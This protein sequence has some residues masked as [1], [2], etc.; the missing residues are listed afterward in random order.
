M[1]PKFFLMQANSPVKSDS[2][3]LGLAYI[4]AV[5]RDNGYDVKIVDGAAFHASYSDEQ[6]LGMIQDFNPSFVGFLLMSY[7]VPLSYSMISK[8]KKRFPGIKIIAGGPHVAVMPEEVLNHGV[9]IAFLGEAEHNILDI[10][11]YHE[12]SKKLD[13]I[14]GIAFK[15]NDKVVF[16]KPAKLVENL[17]DLPFP[18]R[19]LFRIGDY[20]RTKE[21]VDCFAGQILTSRGCPFRCT[22]CS[23]FIAGQRYR[24]RTPKNVVDE[25]LFVKRKYGVNHFNFIDD[26]FTIRIDRIREFC[27]LLKKEPELR[28]VTWACASR[29]DFVTKELLDEIKA[30]GCTRIT[31]GVESGDDST[32]QLIKKGPKFTVEKAREVVKATHDVGISCTV[33]FM[34]GFP[35]ETPDKIEKTISFMKE[36]SPYVYLIMRGGILVPYPG[37]EIYETYKVKYGFENWWLKPSRF[38]GSDR[39]YPQPLFRKIFF[40]DGGMLEKSGF[41]GYSKAIK[42]K[43]RKAEKFVSKQFIERKSSD[44]GDRFHAALIKFFMYTLLYSSKAAHSVH[45][46]VEH[47][48]V[49][50][51]YEFVRNNK[52]YWKIMRGK[53]FVP[54]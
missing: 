46:M 47:A 53:K 19:D 2:P 3:V 23:N 38:T 24:F 18:A 17:D 26:A 22:F 31:Y 35:W 52:I 8:V 1:K 28:G 50:K 10:A 41:F 21:E 13:S 44:S 30:A 34:Y 16:T 9:D 33:T 27:K 37:T 49:Y 6:I 11:R 39:I 25:M 36:I 51:P 14:D 42:K 7:R 32:L 45:P 20:A 12:G 43:I 5:L 40:N 15:K 54:K 48:L 4:A 29:L